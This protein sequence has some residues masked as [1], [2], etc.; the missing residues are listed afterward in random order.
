MDDIT[1]FDLWDL[2]I[3]VLGNTNQN[4]KEQDDYSMNKHCFVQHLTKLQK[5]T[6]SHGMIDDPDNVVFIPSSVKSSHQEVLLY[7][8]ENNEAMMKMIT[9]GRS[10]TM[11]HTSRTNRVALD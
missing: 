3:A 1:A 11:R 4:H 8:F 5:R 10:P 9:K 2:I 7:V 6:K